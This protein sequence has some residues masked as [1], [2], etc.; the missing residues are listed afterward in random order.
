[1]FDLLGENMA[2]EEAFYQIQTMTDEI[3]TSYV[4]L[5]IELALCLLLMMI[6]FYLKSVIGSG[7]E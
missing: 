5:Y 7:R 2:P 6:F 3:M 1:M 4:L